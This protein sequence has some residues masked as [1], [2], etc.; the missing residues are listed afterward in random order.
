MLLNTKKMIAR[1]GLIVLGILII[2]ITLSYFGNQLHA[3]YS[4]K[5][6]KVTDNATGNEFT[7]EWDSDIPPMDSEITSII[8]GKLG[9]SFVVS[10]EEWGVDNIKRGDVVYCKTFDDIL[11]SGKTK[12]FYI[13]K[14][15]GNMFLIAGYPLYWLVRFIFWAIKTLKQND[16]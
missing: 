8:K 11:V 12:I 4:H 3:K 15:V 13:I 16:V 14:K 10:K 1:E 7:L 5:F 9:K 6:Y 2:G